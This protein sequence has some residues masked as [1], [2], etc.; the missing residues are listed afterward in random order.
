[1]C[2]SGA[3]GQNVDGKTVNVTMDIRSDKANVLVT[4]IV[5]ISNVSKR[6]TKKKPRC[7][8]RVINVQPKLRLTDGI[9]KHYHVI[10]LIRYYM[11][12]IAGFDVISGHFKLILLYCSGKLVVY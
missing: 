7:V 12:T 9:V 1:M 6:I 10:V 4:G 5:N 3:N 11:F 8:K 2:A